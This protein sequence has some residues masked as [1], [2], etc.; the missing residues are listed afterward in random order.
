MRRAITGLTVALLLRRL[1]GLL[2][3]ALGER[4][5]SVEMHIRSAP[6]RP[7]VAFL[8][9]RDSGRRVDGHAVCLI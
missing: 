6:M 4:V 9:S 3:V 5:E 7:A 2:K 8:Q 1:G